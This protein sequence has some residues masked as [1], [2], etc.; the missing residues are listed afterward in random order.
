[1]L[2]SSNTLR[3]LLRGDMGN[4]QNIFEWFESMWG[5]LRWGGWILQ[6]EMWSQSNLAELLH[7]KTKPA[8]VPFILLDLWENL[9]KPMFSQLIQYPW[10][11]TFL[12]EFNYIKVKSYI[13]TAMERSRRWISAA[14]YHWYFWSSITGKITAWCKFHQEIWKY[15]LISLCPLQSR[16]DS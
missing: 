14:K 1:M 15:W 16:Q 10:Y 7:L 13:F 9:V 11:S 6:E 4:F 5:V 2:L 3:C 8:N 12:D